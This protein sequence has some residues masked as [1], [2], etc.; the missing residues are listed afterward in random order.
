MS[1]GTSTSQHAGPTY[2]HPRANAQSSTPAFVSSFQLSFLVFSPLQQ[3]PT[4]AH[5]SRPYTAYNSPYASNHMSL[6]VHPFRIHLFGVN[7]FFPKSLPIPNDNLNPF[8]TLLSTFQHGSKIAPPLKELPPLRGKHGPIMAAPLLLRVT[9]NQGTSKC[10][11]VTDTLRTVVAAALNVARATE[12]ETRLVTAD[13][14]RTSVPFAQA[15]AD[16][17]SK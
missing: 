11:T 12:E 1:D 13:G 6:E 4:A 14:M 5:G 10:G 9:A 16:A 8:P 3:H 7:L 17:T 2:M 15:Y